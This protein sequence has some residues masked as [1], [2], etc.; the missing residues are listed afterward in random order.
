[1]IFQ[2]NNSWE[3]ISSGEIRRIITTKYDDY[4]YGVK[5]QSN[6]D[7]GEVYKLSKNF[8]DSSQNGWVKMSQGN[9]FV[10]NLS[11]GKYNVYGITNNYKQV[12]KLSKN[13]NDSS[14]NGFKSN[15]L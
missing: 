4:I 5:K 11:I 6:T 9:I 15:G 7:I 8:N 2:T 10:D 3:K 1:M 12:Y 13:F 14:Q